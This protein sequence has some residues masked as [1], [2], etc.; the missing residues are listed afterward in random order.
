MSMEYLLISPCRPSS[1]DG[2]SLSRFVQQIT[3][4]PTETHRTR[5]VSFCTTEYIEYILYIDN[6]DLFW[7]SDWFA[8]CV[9]PRMYLY[10]EDSSLKEKKGY[11]SYYRY[12]YSHLI[13]GGCPK[14]YCYQRQETGSFYRVHSSYHGNTHWY[15]YRSTLFIRKLPC[16]VIIGLLR[17]GCVTCEGVS[18]AMLYW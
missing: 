11:Y 12:Y 2:S 14:S 16:H 7:K 3:N 17:D 4:H 5:L 8:Q 10:R 6:I 15:Y 13:S 9:Y 18:R 1:V